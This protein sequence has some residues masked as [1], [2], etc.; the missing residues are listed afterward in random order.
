M[1]PRTCSENT[2]VGSEAGR[3]V[4]RKRL[5]TKGRVAVALAFACAFACV[6][7]P[8]GPPGSFAISVSAPSAR[9]L[10]VGDTLRL[11]AE[12][13]DQWG[14]PLPGVPVTWSSD[15]PRVASV[16]PSGVV[17]AVGPGTAKV[18]AA[19]GGAAGTVQLAVA[20]SQSDRE[21]LEIFYNATD[22]P[23]WTNSRNWLSDR[24]I[25]EWYGV[26]ADTLDR[27]TALDLKNNALGGEIP[28]QLGSLE[29]LETL[30]LYWNG[31]S[32]S[33]PPEL[34]NLDSLESLDLYNNTLSG[35]IPAEL[36]NL[37][38]LARLQLGS[39]GLTGQIP[40]ELG[41][42][43]SLSHLYLYGNALTGEIPP[44]LI[45]LESLV[46]LELGSNDLTGEIPSELGNLESL[47]VLGLGRN[48]LTGE[49][50]A[51][52]GN[53][54]SLE[55]LW[56]GRNGLTGSIPPE[57]GDLESLE[58][59]VLQHN[60]LTGSIPLELGSLESL[61]NLD[62][63]SNRLT[64]PIP[65]E[66][67]DLESLSSLELRYNDL[68]GS[69]P[70]ELGN[71]ESLRLL[72][73]QDNG[74]TGS[75][76]PEFGNLESMVYLSLGL[77]EL[78]GSIP[79]EL[80]GLDNLRSLSVAGN[81]DLEGALPLSLANLSELEEFLYHDTDICVPADDA[82]RAWLDGIPTH[83]GTGVDCAAPQSD[84]DIL[85]I[86]YNE[87][88]GPNWTNSSNW[89]TDAPLNDWYGVEA[90]TLDQVLRLV[91]EGNNLTGSIPKALGNLESPIWLR[92]YRNNLTGSI[93]PELGNLESLQSLYLYENALTGAI[94]P[95]LGNLES[96]Q[97]LEL[98]DNELTGSIPSE[99]GELQSLQ[100]LE[101]QANVLT[102]S[103]P[104]EL[105]NLESLIWLRLNNNGLTGSIPTELG[106][107]ERLRD[108]YLGAN[109][110]TGSIPPELGELQSSLHYLELQA[111]EL[112]GSI[113]P[114]L[115]DLESLLGLDLSGN[116]LTGEIPP[117]LGDLGRLRDLLVHDNT[118]LE[119]ALPLP[120]AALSELD[121]FQYYNTGICV[122]A[123]TSFR[124]WLNG[125]EDH[126]GTGVDCAAP[127]SDREILE[128]LY[129]QTDG[130][131]WTDSTNWLTD[132]PLNDWF[133]VTATADTVTGLNLSDNN[134]VGVLPPEIG[135]LANLEG[136]FLNN[137]RLSGA[138]PTELGG[139]ESLE[140][141]V[142]SDNN[143][144]GE[145]P[146]QLGD[147]ESLE[148]LVLGDNRLTGSI[149]SELG[150]LESLVF[151]DL[152]DN[153]LTDSIPAVL[154][155]LANLGGLFLSDNGLTGSIPP[156]LG[157]LEELEYLYV[158][159][160]D[161]TGSIP[162]V[163]GEIESLKELDLS[164]NDL[165]GALPLSLAGLTK[166]VR[167]HYDNTDVCVPADES[168]LAWLNAI[169]DHR[170]TG[171]DCLSDRDILEILYNETD[172]PNWV[173]NENWLTDAPLGDWY[174][175]NTDASRRV[176]ELDLSG[177]WDNEARQWIPHGLKGT[178]PEEL[179]NL[180]NL[181]QLDLGTN[182]L[183]G[184]IPAALGGLADLTD[185]ELADNNLTGPVLAELS[186]LANLESL[187]LGGNEFTGPI[188][189]ELGNLD[190]LMYLSLRSNALE[191]RI[192]VELGGLANLRRLDVSFN[193]LTGSI[194]P[195]IGN[196]SA[197]TWLNLRYNNLTG[198]VPP[199]IGGLANLS[200]LL[201]DTNELTGPIPQSLL[202]LDGL[203]VFFV[204]RNEGL[205]VPGSATFVAWLR[206]IENRDD[207]SAV[208]FC[209]AADVAALKQLYQTAGGMDWTESV[210]WSGN[211]AVEDWHGVSADTLGRVTALDLSRNGLAGRLSRSLDAMAH[212]TELR[213]GGNP[214][215]AG[216]LPLSLARLSLQTLHYSGTDLCAPAEP[217]FR[218]WLGAIPSHE[219]T[220]VQCAPLSDRDI[221]ETLY[222]ATGGPDWG[223]NDNWLTDAPLGDWYGVSVDGQGRVVRLRLNEN[224]LTGAIPAELGNLTD[225]RELRMWFNDLT[226][227]LPPELGNLADLVVLNL[228]TNDLTGPIPPELGNLADL[229]VLSLG[230]NDLTGPIPPELGK[231]TDLRHLSVSFNDGMGQIPPE[232][233]NLVNLTSLLAQATGLTGPIPPELG[234]LASLREL[235]L[236]YGNNAL[237]GPIPPELGR[238]T[239]LQRL[240]LYANELTGSIPPELGNLAQLESL[241]LHEN[242]LTGAIPSE[243]GNLAN[244]E[245]L[246]LSDN[247][248]TGRIPPTL[249]DLSSVTRVALDDNALTGPLP[250]AIGDLT[251]V[252]ELHLDNNHLEGPV[253]AEFGSMSSLRE[254]SIV[255]NSSMSGPLPGDLTALHRL[256]ALLAGGTEL[257][258]PSNPDFQAWLEGVHKRRIA[259]CAAG[260]PAAA[261]LTQAAQSREFPVPLVAG[262]EALLRVF[263][264]AGRAT[265]AGIPRVRA[266]FYRDDR[267]THVV[268][269]PGKSDPIPTEVDESS[270][271]KSANAE[272]PGSV[273]QPGLEIVIEVDPDGTLDPA[274]GVAKRIP[275]T[276]RLAL[277]VRTMP[278][279]DLTLI[280][281]V[282]ARTQDSSIVDLVEAMA[283][284]P[285][286]HEMLADTR[287]L[288]PVG[289]FA[290]T[291]HEPVL[292]SSNAA[293]VLFGQTKAIW[294]MEGGT[295][296]YKG[297]MAPPVTGGGGIGEIGGR[298]SFSQP[299]PDILAHELG[300]NLSLRHPPGCQAGGTDG[301]F[302]YSG[303]SIGSWG[304]D[305]RAGALVRPS[306]PDVMSYCGPPDWISDYHFTNALR[307]R[308]FDES[309]PA[310]P[311][312]RSLLLWGGVDADAVPHLE[313]AFVVEAP[314]ALP[315]S[316]G[317]Y[318]ISGRTKT[319]AQ[320][321]S[322]RFTMPEIADGDGSSSF[323]FVLPVRTEWEGNLASISLT[324]P[325]G[326][327]ILDE[328][329][330][331]PMAILRN[332]RTGQIRGILRDPPPVTQAAAD[333]AGSGARGVEVLFS[334][335]I[336]DAEE[337]RR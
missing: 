219:G 37:E 132:A 172:G 95:E 198:P 113:P 216:R 142:L 226:G 9:P 173:D 69:I 181:Q 1:R 292:S 211:G 158:K 33:I 182:H 275:A 249:G 20:A 124:A 330:D 258:A 117:E 326:S 26:T 205:C 96:L 52:L 144:T 169:S 83:Q 127:Q 282:W 15:D 123:D 312:V 53:L 191:G 204:G 214:G 200:G 61:R 60:D 141:L 212:M 156:E 319:G 217:S 90:D 89:L 337:W 80:G 225:L 300:H 309:P 86:L 6:D 157:D 13:R 196:L 87:T 274:L 253:P 145:I 325:G 246:G 109:E 278:L 41:N 114:E 313:P 261:Y 104:S 299:Y 243:L 73:A 254:L 291:A 84:R 202:R 256:E 19:S 30:D 79:P 221:L 100:N 268:D 269:I 115:G 174:G 58:V 51:E 44:E 28:A 50:P 262:E 119:G 16:D 18:T 276:G 252:E 82:F 305:S 47:R 287:T 74:L 77:N 120:L 38:S 107:L 110:L 224:N 176:V 271:S 94:P 307:Y 188:P 70:S 273:V 129:N 149:P 190:R 295:G 76:P 266:R 131:N 322:L 49:I 248:L 227:Q 12:V 31:I 235:L 332:A 40:S 112:T 150:D 59:L 64:G 184:P 277:D 288:L 99:L 294:A 250:P 160:N 213:V 116:D 75:I 24:P 244:L 155:G 39:N 236:G 318:Q 302:P 290:V 108:L 218:A 280:P 101:L 137:N 240:D 328:D 175:V 126:Q 130:P 321:F 138:I 242:N 159:G 57:L 231:L 91:L 98:N 323:A 315:D 56:I 209:N 165:T 7:G 247:D 66:L 296:H 179:G 125:I 186:R 122:P 161:L 286:N 297:M 203:R 272:I 189:T 285:E 314:T 143:L 2:T 281:F 36:G 207:D 65:P 5:R 329:S 177:K 293:H 201:F 78:T 334:R 310:Q 62:L 105:G 151:L 327:A 324:G 194:P 25:R 316:A 128:I 263:V 234:E 11:D 134:L 233:G 55:V 199:G 10:A 195:E 67:G 220:G 320:L 164:G 304:Y 152:G 88:D 154:G 260:E 111:N 147:L 237:T 335:G 81:N 163:L 21:I 215:L 162:P 267:E 166:L 148:H 97:R 167:F 232:L 3:R 29:S 265:G 121:R 284:D 206:G 106:E 241:E 72:Q 183:N 35:S 223:N 317:E 133:G 239:S 289:D 228:G 68:T 4:Y 42:L 259:R 27:V 333:A 193:A 32:G 85:E 185:L 170:G 264:T 168:F 197:L 136:L 298:W 103:I 153:R 308:L 48:G 245:L 171:V 192:P 257:C 311:A 139:L 140:R 238:L 14:A 178:I 23:N 336:P 63:R 303:A 229:V 283:A 255:N 54:E 135:G 187:G 45:D 8:T 146:A 301:A 306:T 331:M 46:V 180:S 118:D 34:G 222:E 251:T 270:L 92:F 43:E 208:V 230:S 17:T 22:G 279:F 93:P 102:G 210:G 71:L